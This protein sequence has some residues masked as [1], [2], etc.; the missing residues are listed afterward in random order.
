MKTANILF[1]VN[2]SE[3]PIMKVF[4]QSPIYP[5]CKTDIYE[6]V[7]LPTEYPK[8]YRI[9]HTDKKVF[10]VYKT[11]GLTIGD[12]GIEDRRNYDDPKDLEVKIKELVDLIDQ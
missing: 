6:A 7:L 11:H 5:D 1:A 9:A 12:Y 4:V 10:L 2:L 3:E 8:G